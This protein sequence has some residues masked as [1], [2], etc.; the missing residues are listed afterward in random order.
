M[1]QCI[2]RRRSPTGSPCVNAKHTH[3]HVHLHGAICACS[4]SR[5]MSNM[6]SGRTSEHKGAD[7]TIFNSTL[8]NVLGA[9]WRRGGGATSSGVRDHAHFHRGGRRRSCDLPAILSGSHLEHCSSHRTNCAVH[10]H[11]HTHSIKTRLLSVFV[12]SLVVVLRFCHVVCA[13][14]D[15]SPGISV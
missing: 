13:R 14:R 5:C 4:E 1:S 9:E 11:A 10:T 3:T 7:H 15:N 8:T 12:G 2:S 6:S